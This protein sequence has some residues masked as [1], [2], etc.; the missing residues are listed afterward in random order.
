M[1]SWKKKKYYICLKMID[2]V[3]VWNLYSNVTS[4]MGQR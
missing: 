1:D 4:I 2:R 3:N